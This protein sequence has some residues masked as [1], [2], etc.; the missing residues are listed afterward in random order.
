MSKIRLVV[1]L[2]VLAIV[3]GCAARHPTSGFLNAGAVK[4][5]LDGSV[6]QDTIYL[7]A[8]DHGRPIPITWT[9]PAGHTLMIEWKDPGQK[10]IVAKKC[11]GDNTCSGQTNMALSSRTQCEYKVWLDNTLAKDPIVVVDNCCT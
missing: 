5:R 11:N 3:I 9:A 4:V 6:D 2:L 7:N 10:C 1:S 8:R